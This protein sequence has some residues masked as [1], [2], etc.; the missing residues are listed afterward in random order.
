MKCQKCEKE[1]EERELQLS[2][3]IPKYIGGTDSD[4]RHW[5]CKKCHDIYERILF[6]YLFSSLHIIQQL[7]L[8]EIA[9]KFALKYFKD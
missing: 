5:L 2:H 8:K 6:S 9:K 1:F 4:G 7:K 3:D